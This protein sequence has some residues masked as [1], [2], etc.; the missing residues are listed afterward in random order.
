[1]SP[2]SPL[3]LIAVTAAP[4][5]APA[6]RAHD[7][8]RF[9]QTCAEEREDPLSGENPGGVQQGVWIPPGAG[10]T[11]TV[12]LRCVSQQQGLL[13]Q[14]LLF[15]CYSDEF[16]GAGAGPAA[17]S[18]LYPK[19]DGFRLLTFGMRAAATVARN[20]ADVQR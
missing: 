17:G 15:T 7:D 9:C 5:L 20:A 6:L 12:E 19:R 3:L 1:M 18:W 16:Q 14:W 2:S 10:F 4:S 8:L 11:L 13:A